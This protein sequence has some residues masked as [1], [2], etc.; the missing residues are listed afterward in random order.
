VDFTLELLETEVVETTELEVL[1]VF[2]VELDVDEEDSTLLVDV[3]TELE[4]ELVD[5]WLEEDEVFV[6]ITF[7]LLEVDVV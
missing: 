7:E 3:C 6:V 1:E 5:F 4:L 2:C